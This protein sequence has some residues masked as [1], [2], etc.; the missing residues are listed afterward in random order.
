MEI[1]FWGAARTVTG[2]C[3]LLE[4]NGVK[5]LVDCG[6]F[7]GSKEL[8]ERN[9]GEFPF[10]PADISFILLTHAHIDHSGLIP[11]LYKHG[12]SGPTYAT[13]GTVELCS[14]MLPD[15]G[16]IQEM[17]IE[18][19]NR[20]YLRAGR[21]LLEPI[22]TAQDALDCARH[23]VALDYG[24]EFSPMPGLQVKMFNAGHILGSAMIELQYEENG[25]P[26]KMVFTGDIGEPDTPI[27]ED[28]DII[29]DTDFL[30]IESTYG[31]REHDDVSSSETKLEDTIV[32]TIKRGG[33]VI[34]PAF[35]VDRTQE[36][37]LCF[38]Y[39]KKRG[40]LDGVPIYIDSPL[41]VAATEIF[42]KHK[43]YY[44]AEMRQLMA[45]D[46]GESPLLVPDLHFSRTSE[47][48]VAINN[49]PGGAIIIS[50]SGMADAGRIKHHLK[51]NLWREKST[52]IFTGYQAEG[53]LGRK[54][55]DGEKTVTIHGESIDVQAEIVMLDG[56]SAHADRSSLMKWLSNLEKL[57]ST[58]FVTHGS[59]E[60]AVGFAQLLYQSFNA[61]VIVPHIGER[62][63]LLT[64]GRI[65]TM[66]K[67]PFTA[68]P[69]L[70]E[71]FRDISLYLGK[72]YA[73]R[74]V[75]KLRAIKEFIESN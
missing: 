54:L 46:G 1:T 34:M 68:E 37:L 50:A 63:S 55:V 72:L 53:T 74:D 59:E 36:L 20:K 21:P 6:L 35:A 16:H 38:H 44:D 32:R 14:V 65:I 15:S 33:N 70:D 8:K 28:P 18:R 2:S 25:T 56:F 27:I 73:N 11:K 9:Y 31:I 39:M 23:F 22:Y 75:E 43:E 51:H 66:P 41:A 30:V 71:S 26:H 3:Y 58:I 52:I 5:F 60:S 61:N 19:K 45:E 12:F 7:Q 42:V 64:E 57:P 62:F 49:I 24:Q 47:E 69:S 17:E 67:Q 40:L 10:V 13:N 48:S 29:H 4:H